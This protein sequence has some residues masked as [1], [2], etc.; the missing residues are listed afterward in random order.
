MPIEGFSTRYGRQYGLVH[1]DAVEDL[2][3]L[4]VGYSE[5]LPYLLLN[6]AFCGVGSLQGGVYLADVPDAVLKEHVDG[7]FLLKEEDFG[8]DMVE[9]LTERLNRYAPRFDLQRWP[10][11]KVGGLVASTGCQRDGVK[12]WGRHPVARVLDLHVAAVHHD[13]EIAGR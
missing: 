13:Q 8:K 2:N 10:E 3:V 6:L 12:V 11:A 7:Q 4:V 9:R 5:I 1:Q